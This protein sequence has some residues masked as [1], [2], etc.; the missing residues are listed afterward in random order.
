MPYQYQE[1]VEGN[2]FSLLNINAGNS[3]PTDLLSSPVNTRIDSV[4]MT[5]KHKDKTTL[6]GFK[7]NYPN[8]MIHRRSL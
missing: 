1:S 6:E 3:A 8:G 5:I 2:V 7:S 4:P